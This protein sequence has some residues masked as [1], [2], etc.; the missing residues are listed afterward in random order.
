[1]KSLESSATYRAFSS[2]PRSTVPL[3]TSTWRAP[4]SW[5]NRRNSSKRPWTRDFSKSDPPRKNPIDACAH[6]AIFSRRSG[7]TTDVPQPN[8]T[9]SI[10]SENELVTSRK[11]AVGS[12]PSTTMVSPWVRGLGCRAGS[13]SSGGRP[14]SGTIRTHP[15]SSNDPSAH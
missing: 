8:L 15:R 2:S 7:V 10:E 12:P 6:A 1:M 5:Q 9:R 3:E 14:L 11:W 4:R 13:A